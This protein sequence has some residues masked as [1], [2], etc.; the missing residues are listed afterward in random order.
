MYREQSLLGTCNEF[1]GFNI[2]H[3]L[4]LDLLLKCTYLNTPVEWK[5]NIT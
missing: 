1:H 3:N 5:Q 2:L 4:N